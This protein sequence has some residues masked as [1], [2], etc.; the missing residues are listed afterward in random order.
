MLQLSLVCKDPVMFY[1]IFFVKYLHFSSYLLGR[2]ER[3]LPNLLMA[4]AD[5]KRKFTEWFHQNQI[6][7]LQNVCCNFCEINQGV[8]STGLAEVK[9]G[10]YKGLHWQILQKCYVWSLFQFCRLILSKR[11]R[12]SVKYLT[13]LYLLLTILYLL[14]LY[15]YLL[16]TI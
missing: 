13:I 4:F 12:Q 9:T 10:V 7:S 6:V 2:G 8:L 15:I 5:M 16:L 1:A 3:L 11:N 14:L